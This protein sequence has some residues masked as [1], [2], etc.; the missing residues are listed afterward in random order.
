MPGAT[1]KQRLES[2]LHREIATV[3]NQELRDPRLGFVTITRVEMTSD[4]QTVKA[5]FTVLGD[6]KQR[7]MAT[8]ALQRAVPFIQR[9]YAPSIRTRL[10]PLLS[11]EYDDQEEKRAGI[12]DLIAKARA[13]DP[14]QS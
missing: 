10:L 6:D 9:S 7:R 14:N 1:R 8:Q 4:L 2:L 5:F 11:I 12:V 13:T 3:V